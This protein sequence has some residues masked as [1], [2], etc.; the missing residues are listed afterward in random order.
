MSCLSSFRVF[1]SFYY[2]IRSFPPLAFP[3]SLLQPPYFIASQVH[4]K[5]G[6]LQLDYL[7]QLRGIVVLL[8]IYSQP[9]GSKILVVRHGL[10][11]YLGNTLSCIRSKLGLPLLLLVSNIN[12]VLCLALDDSC[13][14]V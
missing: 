13:R 10:A 3:F 9:S 5:E 12:R 6:H 2:L 4:K 14:L 8:W 11:H 1:V 7:S